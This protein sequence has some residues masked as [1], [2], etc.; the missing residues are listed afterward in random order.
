MKIKIVQDIEFSKWVTV[1]AAQSEIHNGVL[2]SRQNINYFPKSI[3]SN[4]LC[5]W[6]RCCEKYFIFW[7]RVLISC[8]K[9]SKNSWIR[10]SEH[11][12]KLF[13]N[14][15]SLSR[16]KWLGVTKVLVTPSE[17]ARLHCHPSSPGIR[18]GSF[19]PRGLVAPSELAPLNL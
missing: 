13:W 19:G 6:R 11:E 18:R 16:A 3:I 8:E 12:Y 15:L 9:I 1:K 14:W 10:L 5:A 2:F 7:A 4:F 17:L